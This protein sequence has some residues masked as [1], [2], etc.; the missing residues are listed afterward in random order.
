MCLFWKLDQQFNDTHMLILKMRTLITEKNC[1]NDEKE[2]YTYNHDNALHIS[3]EKSTN[4]YIQFKILPLKYMYT[5][6]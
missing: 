6:K 2:S 5:L 1:A 4:I 3:Y